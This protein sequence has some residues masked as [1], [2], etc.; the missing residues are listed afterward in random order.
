[1]AWNLFPPRGV[2]ARA[3]GKMP[4]FVQNAAVLTR[5]S[6]FLRTNGLRL[7]RSKESPPPR[8]FDHVSPSQH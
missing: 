5:I 3:I 8:Q 7:G 2:L 4:P 6:S 1:M